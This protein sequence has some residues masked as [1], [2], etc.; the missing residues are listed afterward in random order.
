MIESAAVE[1]GGL[2]SFKVPT[3]GPADWVIDLDGTG[4]RRIR[5]YMED[6]YLKL[7]NWDRKNRSVFYYWCE[8]DQAYA[9]EYWQENLYTDQLRRPGRLRRRAALHGRPESVI[10]DD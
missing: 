1:R 10:I 6:G 9:L 4:E 7:V 2:L 3:S 5:S 8:D